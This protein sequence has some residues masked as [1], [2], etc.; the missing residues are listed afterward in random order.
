MLLEFKVSNFMSIKDEIKVS[1]IANTA[2]EH[3]DSLLLF[4]KDRV[5]PALAFYGY[6]AV[7]K[8]NIFN[9]LTSAILFV[10][11]SNLMQINSL[12]QTVPFLLNDTSKNEPTKMDFLF[13]INGKKYNY[14][15][16]I[17]QKEVILEYLYEYE[18]S[19][20][21]MIFERKREVYNFTT[22]NNKELDGFKDINTSN[23]LFL[24]TATAWNCKLTKDAFL[25]FLEGID[26]YNSNNFTEDEILHYLDINKDNEESKN[27]LLDV[28][29]RTD[30]NIL[31]YIFE[32][33]AMQDMKVVLPQGITFDK[34]IIEQMKLNS[35]EYQFDAF[36][37]VKDEDGNENNYPISYLYES[38]GTKMMIA[39]VPII[40]HALEKGRTIVV[41]EFD[42]SL[43]PLLTHYLIK[44]FLDKKINK[45]GAQLIFNTHDTNL[46]DS[47]LLR[48]DQ[49]CLVK[50]DE[51][52][53][54]RIANLYE[55]KA[56][57][58]DNFRK[59]YFDEKYAKLPNIIDGIDW[60]YIK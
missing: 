37:A 35:K 55:Y 43:H 60:S 2:L 13:T 5:L 47:E 36:L 22:Q 28:F 24:S 29:K 54:T 4:G 19:R 17:T 7:G 52:G 57:R 14:G 44:L 32:S 46:L 53:Q 49:V 40:Q 9:A 16:E 6:N 8:S 56:R 48:R 42:N 20:P 10:R 58:N 25:W 59:S 27:F 11:N 41:D 51:S 33:R 12:I 23:K 38:K 45:N 31:D 26:T 30:I 1:C 15:F 34:N 21:S 3:E 39:Y 18:S 50:K